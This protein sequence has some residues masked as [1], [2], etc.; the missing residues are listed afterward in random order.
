MV[1][2][3]S[4]HDPR[5]SACKA[6]FSKEQYNRVYARH[7]LLSSCWYLSFSSVFSS[8]WACLARGGGLGEVVIPDR[9][10][11]IVAVLSLSLMHFF[12]YPSQ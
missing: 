1:L 4:N 9:H 6:S 12:Q 3:P 2:T 7:D 8:G 5:T 11:L 10:R